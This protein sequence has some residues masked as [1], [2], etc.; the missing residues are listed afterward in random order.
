V[1]G[2]GARPA[3][4]VLDHL[5]NLLRQL[6]LDQV[7]GLE[8]ENQVRFQPP[9]EDWRTVVANLTVG[10]QP[11]NALNV[12]LAD[13]RENRRIR[14]NEFTTATENGAHLR[15][16]A[17]LRV[18]CHYLITA[19]SPA[20]ATPAVEPTVD[21]HVLLYQVLGVLN[22][23]VPLNPS[24][25]YPLGSPPL[26]AV[27][28]LIREADLPTV[29]APADGFPKLAEFWGA[30]GAE[31][32][33]RPGVYLVVTLPV[34]LQR[35]LTGPLVTTRILEFRQSGS[36]ESAEV[37]IQIG[38]TVQDPAGEPVPGAWVRLE[39][40]GGGAL[41]TTETNEL[42]RFTFGALRTAPYRLRTRAAGLGEQVRDVAVPSDTGEY[43]LRF[44]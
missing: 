40:P 17:P 42:G 22:N 12:Y 38:G 5:D 4:R 3:T 16:R 19:W 39:T 43:D 7:P 25:I 28:E 36:P 11:A 41:E 37:W 21:E 13:L 20:T 15:E 35:E 9:D 32:R 44:P 31:G 34:A 27:P 2:P 33:W 18:D 24:R 6:F 10:G 26:A 30:M 29:V 1:K 8:S 14:S 23:N